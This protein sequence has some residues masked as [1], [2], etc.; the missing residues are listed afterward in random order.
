MGLDVEF[1]HESN[2]RALLPVARLH[3]RWRVH[4]DTE[5]M[6]NSVESERRS[7]NVDTA[8]L[9]I[10]VRGVTGTVMAREETV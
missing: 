8:R 2:A 4:A 7:G 1:P 9:Q 6:D 5:A 10:P 3:A